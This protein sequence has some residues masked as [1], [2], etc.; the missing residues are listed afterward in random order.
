MPESDARPYAAGMR[1]RSPIPGIKTATL[2]ALAGAASAAAIIKYR[3]ASAPLSDALAPAVQALF[4]AIVAAFGITQ[5][6]IAR[7]AMQAARR[8]VVSTD[9]QT[10]VMRRQVQ[11]AE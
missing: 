1:R 9:E 8:T 10:E 7:E 2:L 11:Q 3:D 6:L 5:M 4:A